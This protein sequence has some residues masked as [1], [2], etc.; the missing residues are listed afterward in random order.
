MWGPELLD[1]AVGG[2]IPFPDQVAAS[3][4]AIGQQAPPAV[5]IPIIP[6][7]LPLPPQPPLILPAQQP[8]IMV[9]AGP[10]EGN[11]RST[12]RNLFKGSLKESDLAKNGVK[13][14]I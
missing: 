5:P 6:P 7:V 9:L 4:A 1:Q 14:G 3:L 8:H 10:P 11:R 13:N 2:G 12:R